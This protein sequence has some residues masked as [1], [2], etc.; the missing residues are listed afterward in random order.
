ML[1]SPV[2][3]QSA[4]LVAVRL[5]IQPHGRGSAVGDPV[6]HQ[7]VYQGV[8]LDVSWQRLGSAFRPGREFLQDIRRQTAGG[9]RDADAWKI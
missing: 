1:I 4:V 6:N 7:V 8:L 5:G 3:I 2:Q 9:V